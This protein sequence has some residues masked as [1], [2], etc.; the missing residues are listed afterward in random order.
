MVQTERSSQRQ[1]AE[2]SAPRQCLDCG[3]IIDHLPETRCPECG[4]DFD[5]NKPETYWIRPTGAKRNAIN[6]GLKA[7]LAF[8]ATFASI[9]MYSLLQIRGSKPT[10]AGSFG[11]LAIVGIGFA[12]AYVSGAVATARRSIPPWTL[13]NHGIR[14][15]WAPGLTVLEHVCW[16]IAGFCFAIGLLMLAGLFW[17]IL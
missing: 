9:V 3:Y 17:S 7:A 5:P 16:A 11:L 13:K 14:P 4:K 6:C 12:F 2:G 8:L 1:V 10:L 15:I